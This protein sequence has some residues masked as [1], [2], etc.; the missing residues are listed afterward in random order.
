MRVRVKVTQEHI[1]RGFPGAPETCPIAHAVR[2][3]MP[4][5]R[6]IYVDA[7]TPP[8]LTP[9]QDVVELEVPSYGGFMSARIGKLSKAARDFIKAFDRG[10]DVKPFT[11]TMEVLP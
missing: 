6:N 1:D 7:S 9:V 2:D 11:F 10:A 4:E 8:S 3:A 5:A